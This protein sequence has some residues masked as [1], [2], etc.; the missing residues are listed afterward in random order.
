MH[1]LTGHRRAVRALAYAPAGPPLLASAGDDQTVRLWSPADGAAVAVLDSRRDGLLALSFSADGRHLITGGR[2]GSLI[3]WA[4]EA[5]APLGPPARCAGPVVAAAFTADG[6]AVLAGLRSQEYGDD[7]GRLVRLSLQPPQPPR[8]LGWAGDVESADFAPSRDLFAVVGHGRGL[9]LWEIA[10]PPPTQPLLWLPS[11]VRALRFSPGAARRLAVATGRAVQLCDVD[12]RQ[13]TVCCA[14]HRGEV[15]DLAFTPD[16]QRL[17][18]AGA[19]HSARLW[20]AETG[21]QLAAWDWGLGP[22]RAVAVAA[23]GMTAACGG[24][25]GPVVVWDLDDG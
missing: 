23:D 14:G 13:R 21:R 9:H 18:T 8:P 3:V 22:L 16:G 12:A 1:S 4:V 24:E 10:R 17:V 2:A 7:L 25:K 19:D 5:R 15:F 6:A 11:R 20:E